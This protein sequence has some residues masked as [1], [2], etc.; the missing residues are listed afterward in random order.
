[1]VNE[2]ER[3][4]ECCGHVG[5]APYMTAFMAISM[6]RPYSGGCAR[7][8]RHKAFRPALTTLRHTRDEAGLDYV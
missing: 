2:G 3:S 1:M 5:T 4:N 8:K 7:L 6:V